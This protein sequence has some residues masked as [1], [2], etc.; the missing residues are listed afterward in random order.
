MLYVQSL[1]YCVLMLF[2]RLAILRCYHQLFRIIRRMRIAISITT[3]IVVGVGI[4][5]MFTTIF[6]C[7]PIRYS[8]NKAIK[9]HCLDRNKS[10]IGGP[11]SSFFLDLIVLIL[12]LECVW[13][14]QLSIQKKFYLIFVFSVGGL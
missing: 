4:G 5:S 11:I 14:L 10:Y 6:Q 7:T 1:L 9:G 12:P 8:W 3:I 13:K 2:I